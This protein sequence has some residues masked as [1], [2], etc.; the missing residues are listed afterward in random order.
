MSATLLGIV[1]VRL[2]NHPRKAH[3]VC[4]DCRQF[5]IRSQFSVLLANAGSMEVEIHAAQLLGHP[6]VKGY[7]WFAQENKL[8]E[9]KDEQ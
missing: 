6:H 7:L 9:V 2:A 5:Y 4:L 8:V 3:A 1:S